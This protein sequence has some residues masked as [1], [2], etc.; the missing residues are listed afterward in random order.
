MPTPG[1]VSLTLLRNVNRPFYGKVLVYTAERADPLLSLC[2]CSVCRHATQSL[3]SYSLYFLDA[4]FQFLLRIRTS[5]RL[6]FLLLIFIIHHSP[7]VIYLM[8]SGGFG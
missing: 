6:H 5:V 7:S 1:I 2:V 3:I 8:H 4:S